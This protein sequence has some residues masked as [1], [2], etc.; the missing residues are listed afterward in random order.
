MQSR[1]PLLSVIV[2]VFNGVETLQQCIDSVVSQTYSNIELIIIDGAS[3]D[4]TVSLLEAN[5]GKIHYWISEQDGGIYSAWNKGVAKA[6]G[7]WICFLGADDYLWSMQSIS[8]LE[9]E[10]TKLPSSVLI[11]YGQ[12]MLLNESAQNIHLVGEPWL[13]IKDRFKQVMCIP[14]QGVLHRRSLFEKKGHFDESFRIAGDYEFLL[15]ELRDNDAVFIAGPVVTGMRQGGISSAPENSLRALKE[16]RKAQ[17]LHGLKY[18]GRIWV[19]AFIR[20]HIKVWLWGLFGE[21]RVRRILDFYRRMVKL[22]PYW[23]K[24]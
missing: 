20:S 5:K 11:A 18:P 1:R 2:A 8:E 22:P 19:G 14:H 10:L 23:T 21:V 15:R 7:E 24:L 12:V 3:K 4:G 13:D 6:K 17:V 9:K 16:I